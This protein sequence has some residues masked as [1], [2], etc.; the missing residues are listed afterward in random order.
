MKKCVE[1]V[2][3]ICLLLAVFMLTGPLAG[4]WKGAGGTEVSGEGGK[5]PVIVLDAGHGGDDPGKVGINNALE[6]EINLAVTL[7]V[8]ELLENEGVAEKIILTREDDNGLYDSG[9]SNKKVA[10]LNKRC[11]IIEKSKA[12]FVVSIHQ[13]SYSDG[14]I[15]GAQVFYYKS[16]EK[17]KQL[18]EAI[19]NSFNQT[20]S[21]N[22]K[23]SAKANGDYYMLLHV[24]CPIVIAECGFL[25][26]W[27]EAEKLTSEEYQEQVAEAV[28]QGILNYLKE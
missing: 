1:F 18:A 2:M 8:K 7:K 19:Q 16:S 21:S 6:K 24:P 15:Q 11:E 13:N 28:C 20:I 14:A 22:K 12:D 3:G 26:N 27:D 23:R 10:D 5:L 9:D 4:I 25:S 17:G